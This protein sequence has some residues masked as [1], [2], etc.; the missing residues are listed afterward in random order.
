[1]NLYMG[2]RAS[3]D[4]S[5]PTLDILTTLFGPTNP[6]FKRAGGLALGE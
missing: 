4:A 2:V 3:L 6:Q 5:Q 1:M